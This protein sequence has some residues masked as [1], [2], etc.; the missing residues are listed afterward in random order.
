MLLCQVKRVK[1]QQASDGRPTQLD[2]HGLGTNSR[3]HGITPLQHLAPKVL[4]AVAAVQTQSGTLAS[5]AVATAQAPGVEVPSLEDIPPAPLDLTYAEPNELLPLMLKH[6]EQQREVQQ[7]Q[8]L[9]P[10]EHALAGVPQVQQVAAAVAVPD[11][12]P[13]DALSI[14]AQAVAEVHDPG[15]L[16]E[17]H[18]QHG[19]G[20]NSLP[21]YW[22]NTATEISKL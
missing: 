18:M 14:T 4:G 20:H 12:A 2:H 19:Q 1:P 11:V 21:C 16:T 15:E 17:P 10:S 3:E 7:L 13:A 22:L 8:Q 9:G 5:S 6:S